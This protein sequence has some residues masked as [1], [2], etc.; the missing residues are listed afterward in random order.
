MKILD[1]P[2]RSPEWLSARLGLPT[3][4]EFAPFMLAATTKTA[5]APDLLEIVARCEMWLATVP[6]GRA[7]QLAC[8]AAIAIATGKEI[9]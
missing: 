9:A 8:Q 3:A 2:Q 4:S 6:E 1:F 7:M 5:A